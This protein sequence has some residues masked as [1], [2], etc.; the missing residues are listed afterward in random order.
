MS[1]LI[2]PGFTG[3]MY[4]NIMGKN[5]TDGARFPPLVAIHGAARSGI[6]VREINM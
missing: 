3:F 5:F 6:C 4:L 1:K 2:K